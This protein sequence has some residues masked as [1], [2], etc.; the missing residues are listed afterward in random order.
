LLRTVF[1]FLLILIAFNVSSDWSVVDAAKLV[2]AARDQIGVTM[3]YDPGYQSLKYPMGDV[4][5]K[6][7]VCS[8]VVVRALRS[9]CGIDLQKDI[10]EDMKSNWASYPKL[11]GLKRP[12]K[13]IDHRRVP[14]IMT[15]F[16]RKGLK[17]AGKSKI[18]SGDIMVWDISED[19]KSAPLVH[20]GIVSEVSQEGVTLVV[21]NIGAGTVE[22]NLTAY[23]VGDH[24]PWKLLGHYRLAD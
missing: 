4:A 10:H 2:A 19:Q 17:C 3:T 22:Q 20:I 13:N 21:H 24:A 14:N 16:E 6:T 5:A 9:C 1:V 7:G 15:L 23:V 8:D 11:W 12:D 18:K